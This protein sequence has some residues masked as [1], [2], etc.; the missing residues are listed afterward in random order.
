MYQ[1]EY[2]MRVLETVRGRLTYVCF[3]SEKEV[4]SN[5]ETDQETL[6]GMGVIKLSVWCPHCWTAHQISA[7]QAYIER[8]NAHHVDKDV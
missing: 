4:V 6:R 8:T 1:A 2:K 3:D 5:I 7:N